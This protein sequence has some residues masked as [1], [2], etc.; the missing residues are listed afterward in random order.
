[1]KSSVQTPNQQTNHTLSWMSF[2]GL[3]LQAPKV[4]QDDFHGTCSRALLAKLIQWRRRR[5]RSG[6]S[7][8]QGFSI[9]ACHPK[10]VWRRQIHIGE[11]E[12]VKNK[13]HR[14]QPLLHCWREKFQSASAGKVPVRHRVAFEK[15]ELHCIRQENSSL[16]LQVEKFQSTWDIWKETVFRKRL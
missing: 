11:K 7:T 3:D 13:H 8:W 4:P 2:G 15:K 16:P 1:M 14:L 6:M 12:L 5:E 10:S 9:C